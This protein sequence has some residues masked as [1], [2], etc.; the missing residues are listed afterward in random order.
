MQQSDMPTNEKIA[1]RKPL[2]ALL[3]ALLCPGLGLMYAGRLKVG[4]VVFAAIAFGLPLTLVVGTAMQ[5]NL[6]NLLGGIVVLGIAAAVFQVIWSVFAAKRAGAGYILRP[7]NHAGFYIVM[8]VLNML[9]PVSRLAKHIAFENYKVTSRSMSPT[10]MPGDYFAATKFK[11]ATPGDIV[12]FRRPPT[13]RKVDPNTAF[14]CRIIAAG[15]DT[16][17]VRDDVVY[18]NGAPLPRKPVRVVHLKNLTAPFAPEDFKGF[19]ETLGGK[20]YR[21]LEMKD[22]PSFF[23]PVTVPPDHYFVLGDN[24]DNANDS[25]NWGT[26]PMK[27]ILGVAESI[28]ISIKSEGGLRTERIGLRL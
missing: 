8:I 23:G 22:M 6:F 5:I 12:L 21:V 4:L 11:Q 14:V 1:K 13:D 3:L 25:R 2:V 18:I 7:F 24:R 19:E 27:N 28:W 20:T 9:S 17:E 16:V 15:G 10:L 26:L